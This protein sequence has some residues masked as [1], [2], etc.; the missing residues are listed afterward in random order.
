MEFLKSLIRYIDPAFNL[1]IKIPPEIVKNRRLFFEHSNLRITNWYQP[2]LFGT[3]IALSTIKLISPDNTSHYYEDKKDVILDNIRKLFVPDIGGFRNNFESKSPSLQ[4]THSAL[5]ILRLIHGESDEKWDRNEFLYFLLDRVFNV[6]NVTSKII[7]FIND[8]FNMDDG[9]YTSKPK[10]RYSDVTSTNSANWILFQLNAS[11][12]KN[13]AKRNRDFIDDVCQKDPDDDSI[14]RCRYI[15]RED[16]KYRLRATVHSLDIC[17]N[18]FHKEGTLQWRLPSDWIVQN[19]NVRDNIIDLYDALRFSKD[20]SYIHIDRNKIVNFDKLIEDSVN[21]FCY[22]GGY[23]FSINKKLVP[24]LLATYYALVIKNEINKIRDT[25]FSERDL[26]EQ[27][28]F[29]KAC[30]SYSGLFRIYP[31]KRKYFPL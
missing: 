7:N 29:I 10:T 15:A 9:G 25:S 17:K 8:H 11:P 26:K 27:F 31:Y 16:A 18:V 6:K 28:S 22:K 13:Y 1:Y 19:E 23:C 30:W 4:A 14:V 24:N 12:S 20:T 21:K 2:G 5:R 3:A